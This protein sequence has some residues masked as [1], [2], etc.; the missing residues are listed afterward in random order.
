MVIYLVRH[1]ETLEGLEGKILGSLDGHLSESG[2]VYAKKI[3][4]DLKRAVD[5][6]EIIGRILN[7][8]ILIEP[9]LRERA[10]GIAD[11]E[12]ELQT[13]IKDQIIKINLSNS[14]IEFLHF[15]HSELSI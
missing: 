10:A 11:G 4:G 1:G 15:T 14:E 5:T 8:N 7:K 13:K 9:L 3:A 6:A 2:I 12:K